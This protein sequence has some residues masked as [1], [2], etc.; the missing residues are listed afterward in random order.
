MK[1]QTL[2]TTLTCAL[3]S[4][5]ALSS[6]SAEK[7]LLQ[8]AVV[9][10]VD[11]PDLTPGEVLV[12]GRTILAVDTKVSQTADRVV[13]LGSAHLYPG[14]IS[15]ATTA[16]L[17]EIGAV[18]ATLDF[19]EV[20]EFKPDVLSWIAVN[21][22][23]ELLP[24]ARANG[25]THIV[26]IPSG[27][28]ISGQSAVIALDGWTT[29]QMTVKAPAV[30]NLKWPDMTLD[31]RPKD[32]F[33]DKDNWKSLEDQAKER[34]K[35][36]REID[37]FFTEAEAYHR[38]RE[39]KTRNDPGY[40]PSWEAMRPLLRGEARLMIHADEAR[41]ITN[42]ISWAE[43]HHYS[44]I[45]CG[46][47]EAWKLAPELAAKKI[48]VIFS[49]VFNQDEGMSPSPSH[50]VQAYDVN[51]SAPSILQKA[52]VTLVIGEGLGADGASNLRNLPYAAAQAVAF[53]LSRPDAIK[54]LTL[55]PAN[56]LGVAEKLGSITPGKQATLFACT[57]D[58]LDIR[59]NVT[60]V[61]I[62]GHEVS[63]ETRHTR[64]YQKYKS[65]PAPA[66]AGLPK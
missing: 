33:P 60:H 64:L 22:D 46:G 18:R 66:A 47:R 39:G 36:L 27:G 45:L 16:G 31:T 1:T 50:D 65:R 14:L 23:S 56:A 35:K 19:N 48:P 43:K 5:A 17:L 9:H 38:A 49:R 4:I 53:G 30:L 10:R 3:L 13:N 61:W 29:E 24:V 12:E 25:I 40:A 37:D 59:Q 28:I 52:G 32:Q 11:A 62:A 63:L 58:I 51:F 8:A 21:P 34:S 26:P 2:S 41:Q 6:V 15:A 20:G 7:I 42:A 55:N 54:S 44:V 57:G